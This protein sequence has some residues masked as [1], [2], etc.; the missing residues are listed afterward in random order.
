M[1]PPLPAPRLLPHPKLALLAWLATLPLTACQSCAGQQNFPEQSEA[2]YWVND[3]ESGV[4][5]NQTLC[6]QHWVWFRIQTRVPAPSMQLQ[7]NG[8]SWA[9]TDNTEE[10]QHSLSIMLDAGYDEVNHRF[11]TL[12]FIAVN[13]TPPTSGQS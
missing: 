9:L 2:W 8:P 11:T 13:G 6:P 7:Q 1:S 10:Q 4:P 12:S 5:A 3:L